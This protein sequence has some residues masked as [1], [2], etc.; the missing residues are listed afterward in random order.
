MKLNLTEAEINHLR[1]LLAWT[2]CEFFLDE[3]AHKGM[4]HALQ[5]LM[6]SGDVSEDK[7]RALL[8]VKAEQIQQVP[9]Y[10]RQAIKMLSKTVQAH[11]GAD[12]PVVD[13]K[14]CEQ[15]QLPT[16]TSGR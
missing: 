16:V 11:D 4:A 13:A 1:R 9:Q 5:Q 12:R 8:T 7:A 14:V 6:S 10:V 2:R 15:R 3:N